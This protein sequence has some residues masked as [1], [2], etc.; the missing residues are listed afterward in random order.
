MKSESQP[1]LDP[2][3]LSKTLQDAGGSSLTQLFL[4]PPAAELALC[5]AS[6]TATEEED[7]Q[8]FTQI[9]LC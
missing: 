3:T 7:E 9:T 1:T 4:P 8:S 6:A 5:P 2:Q